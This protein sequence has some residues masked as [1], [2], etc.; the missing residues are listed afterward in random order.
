MKRWGSWKFDASQF[1][2][3]HDSGCVHIDLERCN[4]SAEVLDVIAQQAGK[5]RECLP[6]EDIGDLVIAFNELLRLQA[7]VCSCGRDKRVTDVKA[8][9]ERNLFD[10]AL[11]AV[12]CHAESGVQ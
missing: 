3:V 7:N 4:S 9:I 10:E 1:E 8:L 2:L 12:N 6:A 5:S 11:E